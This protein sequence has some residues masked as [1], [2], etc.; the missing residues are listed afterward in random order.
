MNGIAPSVLECIGNTALVV[1][2]KIVPPGCARVVAKL[3]GANPTGTMND[4][5][6]EAAIAAAERDGRLSAGG[7]IVEYTGGSTGASLAPVC[8]AKGYRMRIVASDAFSAEKTRT[9]LAFGAEIIS[10]PSEEGE[11][12]EALIRRMIETARLTSDGNS[13]G[14]G[15]T[16]I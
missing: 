15:P 16:C 7:T 14:G 6:A 2:G 10:V 9:M 5:M 1:L 8:A 13:A 11:I 4:R 3:E 12:T